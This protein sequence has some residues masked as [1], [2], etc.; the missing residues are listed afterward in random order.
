M[1]DNSLSP[2][3][4]ILLSTG[5]DQVTFHINMSRNQ[6]L[7]YGKFGARCALSYNHVAASELEIPT[8]SLGG[9][10]ELATADKV[11]NSVLERN[12]MPSSNLFPNSLSILPLTHS[13]YLNRDCGYIASTL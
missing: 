9:S 12:M 6:E 5:L 8:P 1:R 13:S 11:K 4:Q 3:H 2:K 10:N 7:L